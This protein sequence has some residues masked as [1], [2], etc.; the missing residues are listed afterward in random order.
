[1]VEHK[2]YM[3]LKT[4]YKRYKANIYQNIFRGC[5]LGVKYVFPKKKKTLM[6]LFCKLFNFLLSTP[7][8]I[9]STLSSETLHISV[10]IP[11]LRYSLL[12]ICYISLPSQAPARKRNRDR[13]QCWLWRHSTDR[14][15]A[16]S[17]WMSCLL[18]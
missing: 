1:M 8:T 3:L 13:I 4:H 18:L 11:T 2:Y 17:S 10:L 12:F 5:I 16:T 9:S 7:Q 6:H 15:S 14:I